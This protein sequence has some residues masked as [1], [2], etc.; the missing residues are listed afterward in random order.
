MGDIIFAGS[1]SLV[2]TGLLS[3]VSVSDT[4]AAFSELMTYIGV[5]S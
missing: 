2:L 3:G 4:V 1:V 5:V